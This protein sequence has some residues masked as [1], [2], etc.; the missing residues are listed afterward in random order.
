MNE[1]KKLCLPNVTLAAMSSVHMYETI[2]ALQYSMRKIEF[3]DV[4]LIT[5]KKPLFLPKG[6]RY[7][8]TS[9]LTCI[10]DFNYKAVYELGQHIHTDF[11][12]LVHADGFVVHPEKWQDRFLEY[13]Y[14]G[15]PWPLPAEGDPISYRD[16]DG[17]ICRVGNSVSLR[18]KRFLDL[19]GQIGLKWEPTDNGDYNEDVFL[20][21]KSRHVFEA[22]GMRYAPLDVAKYFAHEHMIPEIQGITPFAF[23]KWR[24]ENA[25]FP[26]FEDPLEKMVSRIRRPLGKIKRRLLRR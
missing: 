9:R 16:R 4:V 1:K 15:S 5:H 18:S 10:D 23:H 3:G 19:P 26:R 12:L 7:S 22:A 24:G 6:I 2:K 17:R 14:I 25:V 20:C 13:D 21:C 8:H 11:M